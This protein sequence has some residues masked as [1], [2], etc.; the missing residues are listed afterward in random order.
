MKA[1]ENGLLK[2]QNIE[3][4]T[5]MCI[6]FIIVTISNQI[7]V[8]FNPGKKERSYSN[9]EFRITSP[10]ENFKVLIKIITL[11]EIL[12]TLEQID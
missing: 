2:A 3:I 1:F 10:N 5:I 6:K 7:K 9:I 4:V 11:L 12:L 8:L